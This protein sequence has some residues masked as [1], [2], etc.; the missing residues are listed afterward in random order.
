MYLYIQCTITGGEKHCML[1]WVKII[2]VK[3]NGSFSLICIIQILS[4]VNNLQ[5]QT[6]FLHIKLI[7]NMILSQLKTWDGEYWI[8]YRSEGTVFKLPGMFGFCQWRFL[9]WQRNSGYSTVSIMH[10]LGQQLQALDNIFSRIFIF[11]FISLYISSNL[12][13]I[14]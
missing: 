5:V 14:I 10:W 3:Q 13:N 7:S 11:H 12:C 6:I 4:P 1:D 9:V 8:S 2:Y